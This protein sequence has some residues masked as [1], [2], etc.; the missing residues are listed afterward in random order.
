M[1]WIAHR[2]R[3]S[4]FGHH[5]FVFALVTPPLL[6]LALSTLSLYHSFVLS[7]PPGVRPTRAFDPSETSTGTGR[8]TTVSRHRLLSSFLPSASVSMLTSGPLLCL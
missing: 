4:E 8:H 1:P 7:L 2:R 6:P 5:S 3:G